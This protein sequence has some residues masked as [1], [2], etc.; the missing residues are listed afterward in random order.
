MATLSSSDSLATV[1]AAY[2]DN[3]GY[4]EDASP[5]KAATFI[6]ACRILMRRLPSVVEKN[7]ERLEMQNMFR[8]DIKA[9]Q[10]WLATQPTST[11]GA[12]R[13]RHHDFSDFRV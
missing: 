11:S 12:N 10:K 5:A 13:V 1:Q 8:E 3:A 7:S 4:E 2:D 6:T 9:A